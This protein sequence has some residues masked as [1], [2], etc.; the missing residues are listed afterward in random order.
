M[1]ERRRRRGF[2]RAGSGGPGI[3][4][5]SN[6]RVRTL[7]LSVAWR[8]IAGEEMAARVPAKGVSRGIVEFECADPLWRARVEPVLADLAA[9]L[10]AAVPGP[11]I[12]RYRLVDPR[13]ADERKAPSRPIPVSELPGGEPSSKR[14]GTGESPR[15]VEAPGDETRRER[16]SRLMRRYLE[17]A[18]A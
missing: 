17:R 3:L 7:R 16:L 1:K 6:R 12:R 2:E 11:K 4:G 10:A 8:R 15:G 18:E 13:R 14:G 5:V 9:R